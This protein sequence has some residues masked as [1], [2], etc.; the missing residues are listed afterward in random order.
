[1]E[2][3]G[4]TWRLILASLTTDPA[5]RFKEDARRGRLAHDMDADIVVLGADPLHGSR[6]FADV[7]YTI[8]TGRV[9]YQRR[10]N[11]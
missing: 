8:R 3:A 5:N 6:A 10:M 9:I 4:L 2:A 1:M 7:R 11:P